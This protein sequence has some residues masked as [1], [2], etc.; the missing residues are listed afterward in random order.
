MRSKVFTSVDEVGGE[1]PVRLAREVIEQG[2]PIL[3]ALEVLDLHAC[4]IQT[5]VVKAASPAL[6]AGSPCTGLSPLDTCKNELLTAPLA[7]ELAVQL[8]RLLCTS[9]TLDAAAACSA[10]RDTAGIVDYAE[11]AQQRI[12]GE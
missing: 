1:A 11:L 2:C 6:L 4:V 3:R 10:E 12:Q 8:R 9:K 7:C 5:D